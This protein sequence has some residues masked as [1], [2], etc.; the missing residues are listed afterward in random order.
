[1]P[2][3]LAGLR[4]RKA[5]AIFSRSATG[6]VNGTEVINFTLS[7]ASTSFTLSDISYT[8]GTIGGFTGTGTSYSVT[9][10]PTPNSMGTG[11]VGV[12]A[13]KFS[14]AAGNLNKDTFTNPATGTDVYETNNQVSLPYNTDSTPPTVIVSRTSTGTVGVAGEDITFTL[15]EASSNFTLA[16]IAVTG[17]NMGTTL[18]QSSTNPLVYTARFIPDANGV[19]TATVG[20]QS[21]KFTDA[22]G[23]D[24]LDDYRSGVSGTVQEGNNQVVFQYATDTTPPSIVVTSS[25]PIL[26]SVGTATATITFTLSEASSNLAWNASTQTGDIVVTGGTLGALPPS[27]PGWGS[28]GPPA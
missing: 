28:A 18:T 22:A 5:F 10:T 3:A 2:S 24:N 17:G 13:G 14:D 21:R 6:M 19:G 1:M 4:S 8:G 25:D 23:N 11:T 20:V 26:N 7:E 12:L 15:S 9:F 16:D 27:P